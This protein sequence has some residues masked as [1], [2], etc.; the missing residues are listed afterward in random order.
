MPL[1]YADRATKA[2][3]Q[4]LTKMQVFDEFLKEINLM[5]QKQIFVTLNCS[6]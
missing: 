1:S 5:W 2:L 4:A 3:T 6:K